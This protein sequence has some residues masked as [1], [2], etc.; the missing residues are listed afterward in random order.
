MGVSKRKTPKTIKFICI[1]EE[2]SEFQIKEN[3]ILMKKYVKNK[4]PEFNLLKNMFFS[5]NDNDDNDVR[6]ESVICLHFIIY[7][8]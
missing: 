3:Y 5:K 1:N 7:D 6:I 2:G 4:W 8:E